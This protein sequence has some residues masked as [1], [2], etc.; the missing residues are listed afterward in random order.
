MV[1]GQ[2]LE[3]PAPFHYH[4]IPMQHTDGSN[5]S[6]FEP[7]LKDFMKIY[8]SRYEDS[9]LEPCLFE[10]T[11]N[12][13]ITE[14]LNLHQRKDLFTRPPSKTGEQ[15][16]GTQSQRDEEAGWLGV[17]K[18]IPES[19]VSLWDAC[20]KWRHLTSEHGVFIPLTS[21]GHTSAQAQF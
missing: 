14:T 1:G 2:G 3:S 10:P 12:K 17:G 20:L 16:S 7:G 5:N 8:C 4:P 15:I 19:H 21:K 6:K 11:H 18:A 9:I 13:P